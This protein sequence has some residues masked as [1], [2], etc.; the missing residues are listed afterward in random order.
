MIK[1]SNIG[2][3]NRIILGYR[4]GIKTQGFS[5]PPLLCII[6]KK[7]QKGL[8]TPQGQLASSTTGI[9]AIVVEFSK[10]LYSKPSDRQIGSQSHVTF[11]LLSAAKSLQL[12]SPV[13]NNAIRKALFNIGDHKTPRT[14]F[15]QNISKL[16]GSSATQR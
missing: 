10:N 15:R 14:A 11:K 3:R 2:C 1:K 8:C 12:H 13:T 4:M 7:K 5:T 16:L 6:G 9:Q